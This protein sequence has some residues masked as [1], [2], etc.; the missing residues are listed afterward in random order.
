MGQVLYPEIADMAAE[1]IKAAITETLQGER[2]VKAILDAYNPTG[3]TAHVNFTTSKEL[4]WQTRPDRSHVN[5]V[6]CDSDWEAEFARVAESHPSVRA[7]VKNQGLGLE[8]PYLSGSTP[9]KYI[10]DFIVQIDDG[11]PDPLNL[12]VEVKGYR[13]ED[14]KDK[15]NTMRS[16]LGAG[17]Q[18]PGQVRALGICRVHGGLRDGSRVRQA[19]REGRH[20]TNPRP[21]TIEARALMDAI[22]RR[23]DGE[24]PSSFTTDAHP[25]ED[26]ASRDWWFAK[27]DSMDVSRSRS[28]AY[29]TAY[30]ELGGDSFPMMGIPLADGY[31]RP[32][33]KVMRALAQAGM[34]EMDGGLF[35][36]T[37]NGRALADGHRTVDPLATA[38][39]PGTETDDQTYGGSGEGPNHRALRLWVL[40][41]AERLFPKLQDV[42]ASTEFLLPSADRVD[43]LVEGK[44]LRM[45]LEVKS[46]DSNDADLARGLYQ[47]VKYSAVLRAITLDPQTEVLANL[48]TESAL[49]HGQETHRGRNPHPRRHAQ[50]HSDGRVRVDHARAGQDADPAGL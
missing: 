6:V 15:A 41:N 12:I 44:G 21:S 31:L 17:R 47:C 19:D 5:W 4:R 16:L 22:C 7:Y 28:V 24:P 36:L 37:A 30:S 38:L 34:I 46:R 13:G 39:R 1:R 33:R 3:T 42:A 9:R 48:V 50:E 26:A 27:D 40:H 25:F 20:M 35:R 32:D 14:A 49:T 11:R 29:L 43:V 18:Q 8:V 23:I 10:P 2:P 45:A